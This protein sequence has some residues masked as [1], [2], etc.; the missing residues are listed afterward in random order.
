M[1]DKSPP[2]PAGPPIAPPVS[3]TDL[4]EFKAAVAAAAEQVRN[5]L[6]SAMRSANPELLTSAPAAAPTAPPDLVDVFKQMALSI[7]EMSH[8]GSPRDK[9]IDPRLLEQRAAAQARLN[10]MLDDVQN[11]IRRVHG[12]RHPSA[13]ARREAVRAISPKWKCISKV[14]L[15]DRMIDPFQRDPGTKKAVP[16]E[17]YYMFEPNHAMRPLNALAERI[18]AEFRAS[19]GERTKIEVLSTKPSWITDNGLIIEGENAP[20]RRAIAA[21]MD[22]GLDVPQDID[23]EAPFIHVLGTLHEPAQ[24]NYQGKPI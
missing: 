17:F 22:D 21:P 12:A 9:P 11:E 14:N 10:A 3:V 5:E 18:Y 23:P 4:P 15:A 24:N 16:V 19:R 2:P 1:V 20:Q 7:A 8:Q 13:E 6:M